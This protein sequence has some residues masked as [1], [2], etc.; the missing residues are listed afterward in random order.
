M[1]LALQNKTKLACYSFEALFNE[2]ATEDFLKWT[3]IAAFV[4]NFCK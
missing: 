4:L 2:E 3:I 1:P